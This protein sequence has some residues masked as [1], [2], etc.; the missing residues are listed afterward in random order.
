MKTLPINRYLIYSVDSV[1]KLSTFYWLF[2]LMGKLQGRHLSEQLE[3]HLTN[4]V[5]EWG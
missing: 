4:R 3:R 2:L 5:R 1:D